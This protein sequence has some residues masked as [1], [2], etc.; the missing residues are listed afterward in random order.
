MSDHEY[1][2]SEKGSLYGPNGLVKMVSGKG[3]PG[4]ASH[5]TVAARKHTM[6]KLNP[7]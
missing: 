3:V 1:M 2:F 6:N 4:Y 5:M 7:I